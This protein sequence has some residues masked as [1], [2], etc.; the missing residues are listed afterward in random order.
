MVGT[1]IMMMACMVWPGE[2]FSALAWT[3][4]SAGWLTVLYVPAESGLI[5]LL[6]ENKW[7]VKIGK[8]SLELFLIHQL[9]IRYAVIIFCRLGISD[10]FFVYAFALACSWIFYRL[11][12]LVKVRFSLGA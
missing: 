8:A 2:F 12:Q 5:K 6:F 11:V 7:I 9:A 10:G 1:I 4:L 3:I